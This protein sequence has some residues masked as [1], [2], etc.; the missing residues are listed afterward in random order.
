MKKTDWRLWALLVLAIIS[1]VL[2]VAFTQGA[3]AEKMESTI[4]RVETLESSL[5]DMRNVIQQTRENVASANAKL[6]I[7]LSKKGENC[8]FFLQLSPK[9]RVTEKKFYSRKFGFVLAFFLI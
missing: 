6:D 7:I 1:P 5:N 8:K 2:S 9:C 3:N 4:R